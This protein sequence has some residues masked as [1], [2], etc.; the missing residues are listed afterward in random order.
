MFT[1]LVQSLIALTWGGAKPESPLCTG[2]GQQLD[3]T[4]VKCVPSHSSTGLPQTCTDLTHLHTEQFPFV[5]GRFQFKVLRNGPQSYFTQSSMGLAGFTVDP[6][7]EQLIAWNKCVAAGSAR[8]AASLSVECRNRSQ[9]SR[10]LRNF[11]E[12]WTYLDIFRRS[13]GD[14]SSGT[15]NY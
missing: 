3:K 4:I 7:G 8:F 1:V 11:F 15:F 12:V 10:G 13:V 2:T 5:C 9:R 14:N 6:A